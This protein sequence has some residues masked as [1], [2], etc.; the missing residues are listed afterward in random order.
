MISLQFLINA[1]RLLLTPAID[2]YIFTKDTRIL[3]YGDG[4]TPGGK[5]VIKD[6]LADICV[7]SILEKLHPLYT[8]TISEITS[9]F[10]TNIKLRGDL[11]LN[12]FSLIG[13]G[14]INVTGNTYVNACDVTIDKISPATERIDFAGPLAIIGT[15]ENNGTLYIENDG[16]ADP[17]VTI[18]NS[19][20]SKI[21]GT[22]VFIRSR[23][24]YKEISPLQNQDNIFN[25]AFAGRSL[26]NKPVIAAMISASVEKDVLDSSIS[27]M[28]VFKTA[29]RQGVLID[30]VTIN[31][32]GILTATQGVSIGAN[33]TSTTLSSGTDGVI[34]TFVAE[35]DNTS[36]IV[37]N[38]GWSAGGGVITLATQG[39]GCILQ[40]INSKWYCIGNNGGAFS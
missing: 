8:K 29:N 33:T 28:I 17:I 20:D 6:E 16:T 40:Y 15:N 26:N 31:S 37:E 1:D 23:G 32:D 39:Q 22:L 5:S 24:N 18:S 36:I 9:Q 19:N 35:T 14:N 2:E 27:G 12:G 13:A 10:L 34:K 21:G 30:S 7:T 3:Y 38:A 11:D 25:L 4:E